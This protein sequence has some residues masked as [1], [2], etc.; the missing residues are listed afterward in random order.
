M[1]RYNIET[2]L[3]A[4]PQGQNRKIFIHN[5]SCEQ[6]VGDEDFNRFRRFLTSDLI[7]GHDWL[8]KGN[9]V[10]S[11]MF[12]WMLRQ[13]EEGGH[14]QGR[15][16]LVKGLTEIRDMH[17]S[18]QRRFKKS[19]KAD[20]VFG[21]DY[22]LTNE[23]G[24]GISGRLEEYSQE[25]R[26]GT[27]RGLFGMGIDYWERYHLPLLHT[28]TNFRHESSDVWGFQQLVELA[29]LAK[30]KIPVLGFTWYSLMDQF[31][32]ERGLDCSP[33]AAAHYPVGLVSTQNHELRKFSS[34]ILPDLRHALLF[35][36][37]ESTA[38][39]SP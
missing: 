26:Q 5:E 25:L 36:R 1:G 35:R 20:T 28:E 13:M 12:Q 23:R 37:A 15:D 19:M 32:W 18:F 9:F 21:I 33:E 31:G 8:L 27:R 16:F 7:L 34:R 39:L 29:Q 24:S 3:Q 4:Q 11:D 38:S 14:P 30:A 6:T 2:L 10:Q 17:H 22:Y